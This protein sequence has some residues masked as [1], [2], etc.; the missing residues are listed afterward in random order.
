[1]K[2][3]HIGIIVAVLVMA[4]APPASETEALLRRGH[5]AFARRNW[6]EAADCYDRASLWATDPTPATLYLADAKYHLAAASA[7]P[8]EALREAEALYRS[9]VDAASPRRLEAL[10]GLGNCLLLRGTGDAAVLREAL[11]CYDICCKEGDAELRADAAHNRERARLLL[12]QVAPPAEKNG[13]ETP[14]NN[15]KQSPQS[16]PGGEDRGAAEP[17]RED[18]PGGTQ[19]AQPARS[20]PG[21]TPKPTDQPPPPGAG[22]LPPVPD[23]PDLPPMSAQDAAA[24]LEAAHTRIVRERQIHRRQIA[25]PPLEDIPGW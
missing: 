2:A 19:K 11:R 9:S 25:R 8:S 22:N 5:A 24:H 23:G 13:D 18:R 15:T 20:E 3:W 12:L 21:A 4:A 17:G 6:E 14:P 16:P 1:M 10:L 7:A